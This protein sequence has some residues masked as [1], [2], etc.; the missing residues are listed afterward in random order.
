MMLLLL[1]G[2]GS[3]SS[4]VKLDLNGYQ[5][6][7][8]GKVSLVAREIPAE[9]TN[10][11]LALYAESGANNEYQDSLLL[12]E[13]YHQ[14]K[15]VL[16]FSQEA[17]DTVKMKG[18]TV[19]DERNKKFTIP[20]HEEQTSAH[21]IAYVITSGFVHKVPKL[22][23]TQLFLEKGTNTILLWSHNTENKNEQNAMW[24]AFQTL[25]CTS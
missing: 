7:Y 1:A 2:C 11:L 6:L 17:I 24:S 16:V 10:D 9:N 18:L 20:C 15:G 8:Q 5:M 13:K 14:G 12:V 3:S 25:Y 21:L 23:M 19:E 4:P 22:Y